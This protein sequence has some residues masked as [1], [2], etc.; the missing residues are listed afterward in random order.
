M[1][2]KGQRKKLQVY[3]TN[4]ALNLWGCDLLQQWDTQINFPSILDA[5]HKLM[6]CFR[7]NIRRLYKEQ[8]PTV[9]VV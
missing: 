4:V 3:V 7:K 6:L 9:Q 2:P 8:L 1:T 5:N